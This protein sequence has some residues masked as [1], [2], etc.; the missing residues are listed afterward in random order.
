MIFIAF[1]SNLPSSF[2]NPEQTLAAAV[3]ALEN[4][5]GVSVLQS[6]RIW[7]SAPVP[8]SDQPWFCNNVVSV[9]TDLSPQDLLAALNQIE[10]D[11]GRVRG[12]KNEAR[13]L[14]I[15]IL[16]YNGLLLDEEGLTLTHPRMETRAFVLYPLLDIAPIWMHPI[17]R[18]LLP[19]LISYLPEEQEIYPN[20][21]T[22]A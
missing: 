20:Q 22:A 4:I 15:D 13:V 16:D 17:S 6:S 19:D 9:E 18:R 12:D 7:K 1:G 10:L 5:E 14:D 21:E 11:F 8:A 3:Q 2:G